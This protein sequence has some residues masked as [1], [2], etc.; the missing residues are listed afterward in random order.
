[1]SRMSS[2]CPSVRWGRHFDLLTFPRSGST[3]RT[4]CLLDFLQRRHSKA[5]LCS[6]H[7]FSEHLFNCFPWSSLVWLAEQQMHLWIAETCLSGEETTK[8]ALNFVHRCETVFRRRKA[9]LEK[10]SLDT[11]SKWGV[12]VFSS[13]CWSNPKRVVMSGRKVRLHN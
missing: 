8:K 5:E 3:V 11:R 9:L 10:F 13:A 7:H 4:S 12:L 1:M 6:Q 2:E